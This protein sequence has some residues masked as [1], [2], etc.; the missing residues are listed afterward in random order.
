MRSLLLNSKQHGI[1]CTSIQI[2]VSL[3]CTKNTTVHTQLLIGPFYQNHGKTSTVGMTA[4][5]WVI[6]NSLGNI[7]H[8]IRTKA[9]IPDYHSLRVS[10]ATKLFQKD[11]H[12]QLIMR[13]TITWSRSSRSALI[14]I[15][16]NDRIYQ[17]VNG[18]LGFFPAREEDT[19]VYTCKATNSEGSRCNQTLTGVTGHRSIDRVRADKRVSGNQKQQLSEHLEANTCNKEENIP[20]VDN[21]PITSVKSSLLSVVPPPK[22]LQFSNIH[23][24]LNIQGCSQSLSTISEFKITCG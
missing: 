20:N 11:V 9:G 15:T 19:G 18:T 7:M 17:L 5:K 6:Y 13:P 22:V 10:A 3:D 8:H 24:V 4:N 1:L 12:K 21:E 14:P 2:D 23:P 16:D